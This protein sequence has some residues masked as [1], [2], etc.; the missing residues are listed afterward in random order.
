MSVKPNLIAL[1]NDSEMNRLIPESLKKAAWQR[2]SDGSFVQRTWGEMTTDVN[3]LDWYGATTV[4]VGAKLNGKYTCGT[5]NPEES[6][7]CNCHVVKGKYDLRVNIEALAKE[8][9]LII[10]TRNLDNFLQENSQL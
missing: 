4:L 5:H 7:S 10:Q 1:L 2:E 6:C 9:L 8:K 3:Y